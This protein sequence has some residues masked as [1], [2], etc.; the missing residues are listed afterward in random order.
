[1]SLDTLLSELG[2]RQSQFFRES[3]EHVDL[4]MAHLLRE[5]QRANVRG[6]YFIRTMGGDVGARRDRPVVHVAEANTPNEA[7]EIHRHL[8]NQGATPFLLISLPEQVRVY[9]SFAY[10]KSNE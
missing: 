7:R 9:T 10:D 3:G 5:A 2:Y 4:P 6:T 8:W 1:M